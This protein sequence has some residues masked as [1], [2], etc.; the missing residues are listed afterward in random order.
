MRDAILS[1]RDRLDGFGVFLSGLCALHCLLGLI[2]VPLIGLGG[3]VLL[4]PRIHEAGLAL[5]IMVGV[6]TLGLSALRHG[7][8]QPALIGA[9]GI[10]LMALALGV[11]HGTREAVLTIAG[12][13]LVATAHLQNLRAAV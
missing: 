7:R 3:G 1:I 4:S 2:L 11:G 10:V 8:L 9:L 12:V 6:V 5:A 13:A